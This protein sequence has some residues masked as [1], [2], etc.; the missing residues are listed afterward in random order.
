MPRIRS[1]HSSSSATATIPEYNTDPVSPSAEDAWVFRTGSGA[2]GT[3]GVPRGL[4]LAL[5]YSGAASSA[6]YELSYRT[7]AATTIRTTLS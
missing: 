7:A 6:T 3:V 4:L 1:T 5:T 2:D